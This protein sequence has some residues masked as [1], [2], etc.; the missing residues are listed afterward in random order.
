MGHGVPRPSRNIRIQ[1][2][3]VN[4]LHACAVLTAARRSA[5][6]AAGAPARAP[7]A[8]MSLPTAKQIGHNASHL[9]PSELVDKC[10][11][12]RL[13]A[14]HLLLLLLRRRR[15]G[16]HGPTSG[17]HEGREG[18]GRHAARLRRVRQHGAGGRDGVVRGG[19]ERGGGGGCA[20]L[21]R[22]PASDVDADGTRRATKL[23]AI[24][25]NGANIAIVRLCKRGGGALGALRRRR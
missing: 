7:A 24:L 22:P 21:T 13:W 10:I 16:A 14:R 2:R 17:H 11:G 3:N 23:D 9:L 20:R 19:R 8:G 18:A 12:S 4:S 5:G 25:L 1:L 6:P 15:H